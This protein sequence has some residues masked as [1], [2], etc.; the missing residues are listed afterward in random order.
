MSTVLRHCIAS[1]VFVPW[2]LSFGIPSA[3]AQEPEPVDAQVMLARFFTALQV[4]DLTG[5][6]F[7]RVGGPNADL[8]RIDGRGITTSQ[9]GSG[10]VELRGAPLD[11]RTLPVDGRWVVL[12]ARRGGPRWARQ[13]ARGRSPPWTCSPR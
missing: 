12:D 3:F 1:L 8:C 2:V 7:W 5:A 10:V 11:A 4:Q 6:L 9:R 13:G